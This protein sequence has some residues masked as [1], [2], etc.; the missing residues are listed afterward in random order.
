L[1][2]KLK[3]TNEKEK[4]ELKLQRWTDN[5]G[6]ATRRINDVRLSND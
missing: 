2:E 6:P 4:K 1:N 5:A 3:K